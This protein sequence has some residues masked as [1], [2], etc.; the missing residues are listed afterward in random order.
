MEPEG[1]LPWSQEPAN[2]DVPCNRLIFYGSE[3]LAP[4]RPNSKLKDHPL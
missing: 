4:L 2:Y 1:S 3:M